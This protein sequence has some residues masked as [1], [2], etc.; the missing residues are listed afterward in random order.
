MCLYTSHNINTIN[1]LTYFKYNLLSFQINKLFQ[2]TNYFVR[3]KAGQ[4][5]HMIHQNRKQN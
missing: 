2:N 4:L 5:D 1:P 3:S